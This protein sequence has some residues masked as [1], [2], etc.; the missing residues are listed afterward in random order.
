MIWDL[1]RFDTPQTKE[2]ELDGPPELLFVHGGHTDRISDF[3]WNMNERLMIA[4]VA[5]D[6]A[7]QVSQVA[8]EEYYDVRRRG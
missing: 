5:D 8:Y 1:S 7:L 4:S 6:N 2:E 3:G